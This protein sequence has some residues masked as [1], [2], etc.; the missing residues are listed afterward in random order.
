MKTVTKDSFDIGKVCAKDLY[1]R[2]IRKRTA[3][4]EYT[5]TICTG[6][7]H[8]QKIC[9]D[10]TGKRPAETVLTENIQLFI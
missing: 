10:G 4:M 8:T 6:G 9:T 1:R 7:K 2:N 3:Q 5:R